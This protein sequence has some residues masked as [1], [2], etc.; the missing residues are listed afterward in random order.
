[1]KK[2]LVFLV[3]LT[4]I[5]STFAACGGGGSGGG[6]SSGDGDKV[7]ITVILPENEFDNIGFHK[8]KTEQ[9]MQETGIEVELINKGWEAV[10]DDV[11]GDLASGGGS[12][13]VI[14]FDNSWVAKFIEN[15]WVYPLNEFMTPE[16][17]SG[18]V[19][20]LLEKFSADGNYYGITTNNDT[21][22]YMYNKKILDDAGIDVP[23]T[24]AE[25]AAAAKTL[26]DKGLAD[27][28]Y[29]DTYKQEQM[30]T[31]E[32]MFVV[33]SFGGEFVDADNNPIVNTDPGVREAY[34]FLAQAYKDEVFGKSSLNVTYDEVSDTFRT[35]SFPLFVQAWPGVYAD[36]ND[37]SKSNIV[38][39]I[40][41][42]DF[43][44]SKTGAEQ[45][46][47]TLPEAM[48][49]TTTS[50]NKEAA[51]EYIQYMSSKELDKERSLKIGSLPIWTDLYNDPDLLAIY[52]YWE[53]F[54]KQAQNLRGYPDIVWVDDFADIVAKV[55]QKILMGSVSVQA[56]LDEMQ[57]LLENAKANAE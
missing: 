16:I 40:A 26:K 54:G 43:S 15:G 30:G 35:G 18:M 57:Q 48:A 28:A 20:G 9:F 3:V 7:K 45:A 55:S 14:E 52:P 49:I 53:Q 46:I 44:L 1:M 36:A 25:V 8:E 33:Y 51:W 2:L 24:W 27:Y 47:L 39:D 6:S 12:Y 38:G 32:L 21:R 50:Q 4:L 22:F 41:V 37:P 5:M 34:E 42:A 29:L 56:G 17:L 23:A 10:A 31:N 19:P 11:L 13:D